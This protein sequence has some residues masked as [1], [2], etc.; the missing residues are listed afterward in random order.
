[1]SLSQ[2]G[3]HEEISFVTNLDL[4]D[5]FG[6]DVAGNSSIWQPLF[7]FSERFLHGV[8]PVDPWQCV[9]NCS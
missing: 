3:S 6:T 5:V 4:S 1:M 7:L 2:L 9:C 8:V